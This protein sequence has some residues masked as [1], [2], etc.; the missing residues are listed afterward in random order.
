MA[1]QGTGKGGK[2]ATEMSVDQQGGAPQERKAPENEGNSLSL[3]V[4]REAIR[5]ELQGALQE[6]RQD[7]KG[8]ST[9]WNLRSRARCSRPSTCS[10]RSRLS[11]PS[12]GKSSSS[13]KKPTVKSRSDSRSWKEVVEDPRLRGVQRPRRW[14][15]A[16]DLH[17]PLGGGT[18]TKMPKRPMERTSPHQPV[19]R[20]QLYLQ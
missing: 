18:R 10:M 8:E 20:Q 14:M 2:T 5:G 16:E 6:I 3:D 15:A 17:L 12:T 11:T 4:I 19:L 13:C 7:I 9:M 1:A